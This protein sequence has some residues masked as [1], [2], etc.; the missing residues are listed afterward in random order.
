[1][2]HLIHVGWPKAGSTSLQRWFA[3]NPHIEYAEGGLGGF[4]DVYD[5]VRRC[6][7]PPSGAVLRVTSSEGLAIPHSSFGLPVFDHFAPQPLPIAQARRRAC[8]TLR[9]MFGE[10]LILIVTRGF[11]SMLLSNYSQYVREGGALSARQLFGELERAVEAGGNPF[12]LD[13]GIAAFADAFGRGNLILLPFELL[14]D[15]P[16]SFQQALEERAGLP[17]WDGPLPRFNEALSPA[18]LLWYPLLARIAARSPLPGGLSRRALR[19]LRRRRVAGLFQ[20]LSRKAAQEPVIPPP[21]LDALRGCA[22]TLRS[23]PLYA[24]YAADYLL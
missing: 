11:R 8:A 4:G 2:R 13:A 23:E 1:M 18:E 5:L 7:S 15:A 6:A 22:S 12:D 20:L 21:L 10:A 19:P 9:D 16:E 17:R 24:P 14:R 3:A